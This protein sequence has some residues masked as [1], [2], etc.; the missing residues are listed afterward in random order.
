MSEYVFELQVQFENKEYRDKAIEFLNDEGPTYEEEVEEKYQHMFELQDDVE[1]PTEIFKVGDKSLKVI[2]DI[3][4]SESVEVSNDYME[5]CASAGGKN[6][7]G[8]L[9]DGGEGDEYFA[10]ENDT[11]IILYTAMTDEKIDEE[12]F[13]M[14]EEN[15]LKRV[16][17][18]YQD[19]KLPLEE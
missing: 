10:I 5:I 15:R 3:Y 19:D 13:E 4:D 2:F 18:L 6:I 17:E 14:D 1:T 12:L 8:Y 7:Y 9:S 16:I 11:V